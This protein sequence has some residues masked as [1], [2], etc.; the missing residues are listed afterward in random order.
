[1][2]NFAAKEFWSIV[3]GGSVLALNAGF[4][5]V[6][7]LAGV[8]SVTVSH[9]TG[10]VTRMA[11]TILNGDFTTFMLITSIMVSF[12]FGS[13]IAGYMVGDNKFRL[14]YSYGYAL[15]LEST[16]LFASF[17]FLKRELVLGEWCAAFACGL[18][19]AL[20]TSY[21][22]AIVRT[23]H[24]TGICTD[25]GNLLGQA[26]R[27]DTQAELWRLR[28]HVPLLA[29][30][31]V[32]GVFGQLAYWGFR[33]N[34]LLFPCFFVGALGFIYLTLPYINEAKAVLAEKLALEATHK[35]EFEVRPIGDPRNL[36]RF[37]AVQGRD[38]DSEIQKFMSELV[39]EKSRV[40]MTEKNTEKSKRVDDIEMSSFLAD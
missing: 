13:F 29:S 7:T 33:E 36:D 16:A 14:G 21:S 23:T 10:N 34:A 30:Y 24:M 18:Q 27:T 15:L 28:V 32:G 17:Y 25:I 11:I 3:L 12:I 22:G 9:V 26:C 31:I 5:N 2:N 4:I 38:V 37:H 40:E 6:V 20:A 8:F 39:P 1:M 35:S 19:N